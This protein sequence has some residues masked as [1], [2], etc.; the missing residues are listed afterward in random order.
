M[1]SGLLLSFSLPGCVAKVQK[2]KVSLCRI[3][4]MVSFPDY[5][6]SFRIVMSPPPHHLSLVSLVN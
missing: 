4:L 5:G 3:W 2:F 6:G 1:A